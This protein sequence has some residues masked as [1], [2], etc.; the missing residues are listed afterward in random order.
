MSAST[1]AL[2]NSVALFNGTSYLVWAARMK[3][4]MQATGDWIAIASAKPSPTRDTMGTITNE[5]AI[6][7]WETADMH[8]QGFLTLWVTY[9]IAGKIADQNSTTAKQIWDFLETKYNITSVMAIMNDFSALWNTQPPKGHPR[10]FF[11]SITRS[12]S[13]LEHGNALAKINRHMLGL[14]ALHMLPPS[15]NNVRQIQGTM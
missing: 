10:P 14:M 12:A 9:D 1:S 4:V 6:T 2:M 15:Y 13:K 8:A 5:S 11:D 3:S 7:K